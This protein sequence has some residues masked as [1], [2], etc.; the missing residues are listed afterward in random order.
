MSGRLTMCGINGVFHYRG[1]VADLPLIERQAHVLRHRGPDDHG[2]WSDGDV[3]FGHRRLSIVDLSQAGHQPMSNEDGSLWVTYNG[4]IY[5]WPSIK[6]GLI[7]R[8]HQLRGNSDTEALLHLCEDYGVESL[9][10]LR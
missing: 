9:H 8:G 10:H 3:A 1:G 5:N 6:P 2:T 4:E 7:A